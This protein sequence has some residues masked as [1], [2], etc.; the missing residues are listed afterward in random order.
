MKFYRADLN[1]WAREGLILSGGI[2]LRG[3]T[4]GGRQGFFGVSNVDP[5]LFATPD[6]SPQPT[7]QAPIEP[8]PKWV[9]IG[10]PAGLPVTNQ[11][12]S[13][14]KIEPI[15]TLPPPPPPQPPK[16]IIL[17]I[18]GR[19]TGTQDNP[20]P[21]PPPPP[22]IPKPAINTQDE[23]V[24]LLRAVNGL[25]P[26]ETVV[27]VLIDLDKRVNGMTGGNPEETISARLGRGQFEG[28]NGVIGQALSTGLDYIDPNHV[29]KAYSGT[30]DGSCWNHLRTA[31]YFLKQKICCCK[32]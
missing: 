3:G 7:K 9:P 20:P 14:D 24:E 10:K 16:P 31:G 23:A 29:Q 15:P 19:D 11:S 27:D 4:S 12:D 25:E 21:P 30:V 6:Y 2:I 28:T 22:P 26:S 1:P 17:D 13:E 8:Q 32:K 5:T 18:V